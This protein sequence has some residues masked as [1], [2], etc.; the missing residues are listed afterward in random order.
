MQSR[1][2]YGVTALRLHR[3]GIAIRQSR[4]EILAENRFAV[5]RKGTAKPFSRS[6]WSGFQVLNFGNNI[7]Q[8]RPELTPI[9]FLQWMLL[10]HTNLQMTRWW[11]TL[12]PILAHLLFD[13]AM[14][15]LL[16]C[17][18]LIEGFFIPASTEADGNFKSLFFF[19]YWAYWDTTCTI[20]IISFIRHLFIWVAVEYRSYHKTMITRYWWKPWLIDTSAWC[21]FSKV[22]PFQRYC[23]F[24]FLVIWQF[25]SRI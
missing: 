2:H 4:Q 23:K 15:G 12:S 22:R 6:K 18:F 1:C 17:P 24:V 20:Y 9:V 8:F 3:N 14:S 5:L 21:L 13:S 25:L 11:N 10:H 7:L 19:K 16:R